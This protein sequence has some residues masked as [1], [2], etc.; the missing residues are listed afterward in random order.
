M[1]EVSGR[2][3]TLTRLRVEGESEGKELEKGEMER[4]GLSPMKK[5][6]CKPQ[7]ELTKSQVVP[8]TLT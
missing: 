4:T 6:P 8:D 2:L 7:T 1:L 5:D 3:G